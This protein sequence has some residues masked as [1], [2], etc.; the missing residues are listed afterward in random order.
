ML[1]NV[2]SLV[3]KSEPEAIAPPFPKAA[4]PS[5]IAFIPAPTAIRFAVGINPNLSI[6][7]A[8]PSTVS[9]EG[10]SPPATTAP[11]AKEAKAAAK[12][13]SAPAVAIIL[14]AGSAAN[15]SIPPTTPSITFTTVSPIVLISAPM[16]FITFDTLSPIALNTPSILFPIFATLSPIAFIIVSIVTPICSIMGFIWLTTLSK[17]A[18][19]RSMTEPTVLT[20]L[21]IVSVTA[22]ITS[23]TALIA[24]STTGA[25]AITASLIDTIAVSIAPITS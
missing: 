12:I 13:T 23:L 15:R 4:I 6:V 21:L 3:K 25:K 2:P 19:I 18:K 22:I 5:P 9:L 16:L 17:L 24:V 8:I 11:T 20:I 10:M 7:A 1:S 14:P